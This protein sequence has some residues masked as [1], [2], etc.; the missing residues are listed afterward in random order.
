MQPRKLVMTAFGPYAQKEEIDFSKLGPHRF[1]LITGPTGSGKT[2]IL[3]AIT[4]A[5][6]GTPSGD[7][8]DTRSLRS[9]YASPEEKTEVQFTFTHL[10]K[11]YE[12]TRTPEQT[13]RK[14]RGEGM[15]NVPVGASLVEIQPD[16]Q[17]TLLATTSNT[18]TKAVEELLGFQAV[19]FRQL[20]VLPQGEFRRFLVADSKERKEILETLFKTA[21][22]R[23][24]EE[25]LDK[26][27]K[28]L[29]KHYEQQKNR[30]ALLLETAGVETTNA[31]TEKITSQQQEKDKL[32]QKIQVARTNWQKAQDALHRAQELR[33]AW[34]Q[35]E[36][37]KEEEKKLQLQDQEMRAL[38]QRLRQ[39][40]EAQKLHTPYEQAKKSYQQLNTAK[41]RLV[42][43][44]KEQEAAEK[45]LQEKL[46][47]AT[48]QSTQALQEHITQVREKLAQVTAVSGETV[49]LAQTLQ[50]G[51]P[52][53]VCGALHHPRPATE[54][55]KEREQLKAQTA[56]LEQQVQQLQ[57]QQQA[58]E[59]AQKE[60]ERTRIACQTVATSL[61]TFQSDFEKDKAVYQAA[62]AN[63]LFPNQASFL[64]AHQCLAKRSFWQAQLEAYNKKRDSLQGKINLLLTQIKGRSCPDILPLAKEA[65]KQQEALEALTRQWGALQK[66]L[67]QNEKAAQKAGQLEK[68]LAKLQDLYG[69]LGLLADT[70]KGTNTQKLTF[71]SFV[72]QAVLDDVLQAANQRLNK[73]SE[74]RYT[75]LRSEKIM[76]ARKEQGLNLAVLDAFT[77]QQRSVATLSGGEIFFTSLSL[78]LGLSDV[79]E[80]YAG[81]LHLDTILVDEGF[82]SLDPE[83]L[84][85]AITTLLA[86][87]EGGRLVGIISHVAE[88]KERIPAQL[89]I[90]P[91]QQ[92]SRTHFKV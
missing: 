39:L 5:L 92:G 47:S 36:E 48:Q 85:A 32:S 3:D 25:L 69:P 2:T 89:E 86:L 37:N 12:V 17:R 73:I 38:Q 34:Q 22:Y 26:K 79:L 52:C 30:Y 83:T 68:E 8:R 70:A 10:A 18:T 54:T 55:Q 15:R 56:L 6:Y 20:M 76:D 21:Q 67:E 41:A 23:T 19:Q 27:A 77:G 66:T 40:D 13:L 71:S 84:D 64:A 59:A 7:L 75:L 35:L 80:A 65:D 46:T 51:N 63:S 53:P 11:T 62:L 90:I 44:Q 28:E 42:A 16:G 88:L 33:T 1:F 58:L 50:E 72:L 82:G 60:A 49:R 43:S 4:F 78:A 31:L 91:T 45:D 81:G 24:L 9:D 14:Q 61:A 57:K 87:Q 29:K 74:G